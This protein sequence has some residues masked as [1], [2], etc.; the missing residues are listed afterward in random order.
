DRAGSPSHP[1]APIER[2]IDRV[3]VHV[4][5]YT[6]KEVPSERF[7]KGKIPGKGGGDPGIDASTVPAERIGWLLEW[8]R[9]RHALGPISEGPVRP[10]VHFAH[11]T[12]GAGPNVFD[13]RA[14]IIRGMP[15]IAHLR[16]DLGLPGAAR[17]P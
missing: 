2:L 12:D 7:W 14:P 5:S 15:L 16:G 13:R 17:K 9:A 6:K 8:F 1:A 4:R 3:V 10:D 11:F